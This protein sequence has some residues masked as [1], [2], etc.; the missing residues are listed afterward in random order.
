MDAPTVSTMPI[1]TDATGGELSEDGLTRTVTGGGHAWPTKSGSVKSSN[2]G[3]ADGHVETR[4]KKKL[5]W[6][7]E[8]SRGRLYFY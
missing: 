1:I 4:S 3:F 6:Q 2:A 8:G 5:Q 7:M